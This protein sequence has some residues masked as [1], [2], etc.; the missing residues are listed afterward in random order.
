MRNLAV[1][2]VV[3]SDNNTT[4]HLYQFIVTFENGSK[5]RAFVVKNPEWKLTGVSRLLQLPCPICMK[6]YYCKC[7]EHH[8]DV[9]ESQLLE[10]GRLDQCLAEGNKA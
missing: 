2:D 3:L 7:F 4:D 10:N 8:S 6:D 9:I 1:K 5:A